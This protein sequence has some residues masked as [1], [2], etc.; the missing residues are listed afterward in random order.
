MNVLHLEGEKYN[1]RVNCLAPTAATRMTEELL[2]PDQRAGLAP[3]A[4]TPGV[5]YLVSED[6][7]SRMILAAGAGVFARVSITES[8]GVYLSEVER[9]PE[10]IAAAFTAGAD[11]AAFHEIAGAF[12]QTE[13]FLAKAARERG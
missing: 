9:T 3:E 11:M 12:P 5:L 10:A 8:E 7:P 1:I 4:I 13:R 6:S 2:T